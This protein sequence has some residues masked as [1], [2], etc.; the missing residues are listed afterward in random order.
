VE[1]AEKRCLAEVETLRHEAIRRRI[2][3]DVIDGL[4]GLK[5]NG[6]PTIPQ[7]PIFI[8]FLCFS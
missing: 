6:V 3:T 5:A 2:I 1:R 7:T 4:R 8:I